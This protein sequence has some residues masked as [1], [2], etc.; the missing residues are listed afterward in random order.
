M[1]LVML[2][3]TIALSFPLPFL[4][5][6]ENCDFCIFSAFFA[7]FLPKVAVKVAEF[8]FLAAFG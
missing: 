2:S 5:N 1:L 7:C 6:A 8:D 3:R 4:C